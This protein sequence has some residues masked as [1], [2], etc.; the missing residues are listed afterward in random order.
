MCFKVWHLRCSLFKHL[1]L[2]AR[3]INVLRSSEVAPDATQNNVRVTSKLRY[4]SSEIPWQNAVSTEPGIH[5]DVDV[6][7]RQARE[8]GAD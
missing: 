5:F 1:L 6:E 8:I 4:L 2:Q 7:R 3:S